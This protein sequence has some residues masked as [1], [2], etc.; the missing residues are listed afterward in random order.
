MFIVTI[1]SK[2]SRGAT[3]SSSYGILRKVNLL[4]VQNHGN[5]CKKAELH[6][7]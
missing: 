4:F 1:V 7:R 6:Y 3:C 2:E 5:V